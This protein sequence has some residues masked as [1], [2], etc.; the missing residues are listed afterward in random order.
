MLR[1]MQFL[2]MACAMFLTVGCSGRDLPPIDEAARFCDVEEK[3]RFTQEELDWRAANA[4]ANLRKDFKT[5]LTFERECEEGE[6][7]A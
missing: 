6:P 2:T 4:P 1:S 3:R 7:E 5:N